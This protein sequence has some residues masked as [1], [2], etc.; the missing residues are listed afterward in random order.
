MQSSNELAQSISDLEKKLGEAL[1]AD[2]EVEQ[3]IL[4][5]QKEIIDR[6]AKKKDLEI[7]RSKSSHNI[8]QLRIQIKLRTGEFWNSKNQGL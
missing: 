3:A 2:Y 1:K 8:K 6:Q 4:Q 7:S 5:L